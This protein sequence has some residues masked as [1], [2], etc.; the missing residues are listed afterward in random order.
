MPDAFAPAAVVA[1]AAVA[2]DPALAARD[3]AVDRER[4]ALAH[5][6]FQ[7][8][9]SA[10]ATLRAHQLED[11]AFEASDQWDAGL[12]SQRDQDKRPCLT[13]QRISGAVKQI[14]NSE[15]RNP[16]A[17]QV[18]PVD[19]FADQDT[20]EVLQGLIRHIEL[21]SDADICYETAG[22]SAA[23]IGLG[24]VR[25]R[26][27]YLDDASFNQEVILERLLNRFNVYVDPAAVEF[28]K[29]DAR[30]AFITQDLTREEYKARWG[31]SQLAGS[32]DRF[33]SLGD[34]GRTWISDDTVRVAEYDYLDTAPET[35]GAFPGPDG[36]AVVLPEAQWPPGLTPTR[37][38]VV[39]RKTV[40]WCLITG[41]EILEETTLPGTRIPIFPAVGEERV[42][43]DGT[44]DYRGIVR[45]AKDP[46][47]IVNAMESAIVEGIGLGPR[48]PWVM[49][50]G[51]DEGFTDMWSTANSRNWHTLY[52]NA[53]T[54]ET[55]EAIL[56]I[57]QRHVVEPPIQA[58]AMAAQRAENN[59]RAVM[60]F[61]DVHGSE[62]NPEQSGRAILARQHQAEGEQLNYPDNLGRM[63][64]AIGRTLLDWIP[65]YYDVPQ[66]VRILGL[67][68]QPK[69][70]LVHAG[71]PPD[72]GGLDAETF[73][74][75]NG[76]SGIYDLSTGR[77]DVTISTGPSFQSRRQEA[78][79][80]MVEFVRAYP[81]AFPMIG[82][83]LTKEMDWPGARTISERLKKMLPPALQE[84]APGA[85]P[86]LPPEV[87]QQLQQGEQ[88]IAALTQE[89]QQ[90]QGAAQAKAGDQA[91]RERI[92][93]ADRES[94]ERI[95]TL[96][97]Q[98]DLMQS[99]IAAQSS[100]AEALLREQMENLRQLHQ[101]SHD[102]LCQRLE[103]VLRP[104]AAAMMRARGAV[105]M[106]CIMG[107]CSSAKDPLLRILC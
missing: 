41:A 76:L 91:S 49:Y 23:R 52:A 69:S 93:A 39:E 105:R 25:L 44:I 2:D 14:A 50:A 53:K 70:V 68:D 106:L 18:N 38:R 29:A 27:R 59:L 96:Q 97:A 31:D 56:P 89:L 61:V 83:L 72:L 55:G 84:Q 12:K 11:L 102:A 104:A 94:K 15:R 78:V 79:E 88:T 43:A 77:Y 40:Q 9:E 46:Q 71:Q 35:I 45:D 75:A 17:I 54:D 64:R 63:V 20:A 99:Q 101:R 82:D 24:F 3:P 19:E 86:P 107:M 67:D 90:L 32:L 81:A 74:Q 48:A 36:R 37:Q 5:Q 8:C 30:F 10:E 34:P 57:P 21:Q 60:G 26:S 22:E 66:V 65:H 100:K 85:P 28:T 13:I 58:T 1:V 6:R 4:L 103:G 98:V 62:R 16:P 51:Q 80:S 92:A 87:Q 33:S 7:I 95:A 42:L 73:K 47:R